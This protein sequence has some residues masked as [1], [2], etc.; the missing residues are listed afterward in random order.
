MWTERRAL[1]A[2]GVG[3]AVSRLL[4]S[5]ADPDAVHPVD[6]AELGH[7]DLLPHVSTHG[8]GEIAR[9]LGAADNIHHGGFLW[10]SLVAG[11]I[12]WL[13]HSDLLAI[14]GTAALLAAIAWAVWSRVALDTGGRRWGAVMGVCLALPAPWFAQWTATLWGS[15]S[16]A[17]VW[18]GVWVWAALQGRTR[19]LAWA[20]GMGVAWDPLLLPT[21]LLMLATTISRE[22]WQ[23]HLGDG[24]F[25]FLSLRW[26]L[27]L[28]AP[29]A[30]LTEP[31]T[32]DPASTPFQVFWSGPNSA[33][34][35]ATFAH[36]L[37]L[38]ATGHTV[39]DIAFTVAAAIAT[40]LAV[41]HGGILRVLAIAPWLHLVV[42]LGW[43]PFRPSVAHRYLVAWWP[44][45][46]WLPMWAAHRVSWARVLPLPALLVSIASL[47]VFWP[48]WHEAQPMRLWS[49]PAQEYQHIGLDR[50]PVTRADAIN[51]FLDARNHDSSQCTGFS[52]AF[53][54]RMGYP[55]L[56]KAFPEQRRAA[57]LH[58][59]RSQHTIED[60]QTDRNLG[61][62]LVIACEG[63]NTCIESG[64]QLIPAEA[65]N[66]VTIGIDEGCKQTHLCRF[67][68]SNT[69]IPL[70]TP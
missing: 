30:W 40:L 36:H 62:G 56:G 4:L 15:H 22:Q 3:V 51:L 53:S 5:M 24:L 12:A 26:P 52:D 45:L 64:L 63:N 59:R 67:S 14:R 60:P 49:Y 54:P 16:E 70:Q 47:S 42:V 38:P 31:L 44:A 23:H 29:A 19:A 69:T 32:E 18:T 1:F 57:D 33:Q 10:L 8:I 61:F 27:L 58:T 34:L 7:L 13:T 37:P 2:G 55:V 17:A 39:L 46:V 43:S 9:L 68:S 28:A 35:G 50:V 11:G 21:G 20:V 41:R 66:N 48:L 25:G 6:P 65:Q